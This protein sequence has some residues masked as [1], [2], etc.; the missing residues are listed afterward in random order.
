MQDKKYQHLLRPTD[1]KNILNQ[2]FRILQIVKAERIRRTY[3]YIPDM[4]F[5]MLGSA[6]EGRD[7]NE[8]D[9]QIN[10]LSLFLR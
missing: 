2:T 3:G 6:I 7:G 8:I 10:L 4:L 1:T 5:S 9:H